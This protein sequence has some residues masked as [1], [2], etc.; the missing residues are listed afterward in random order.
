MS[1]LPLE[2]AKKQRANTDAL[3]HETCPPV[4][5]HQLSRRAVRA[6]PVRYAPKIW[7]VEAIQTDLPCPVLIE[8]IFRFAR[9][10]NHLYKPAPSRLTRG[11]YASS[12]TL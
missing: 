7:F 11:A 9:R 8:K 4:T 12:R 3:G 10:A 1:G 6:S 2:E 5:R